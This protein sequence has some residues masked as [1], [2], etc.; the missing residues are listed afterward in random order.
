MCSSKIA[1]TGLLFAG[2]VQAVVTRYAFDPNSCNNAYGDK[3]KRAVAEAISM[4]NNAVIRIMDPNDQ[5]TARLFRTI[6]KVTRDQETRPL[7]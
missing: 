7:S 1:F 2:L 3:V 6:W 5:V 4:A